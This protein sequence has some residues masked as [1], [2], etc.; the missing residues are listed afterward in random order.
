LRWVLGIVLAAVSLTAAASAAPVELNG[1][2]AILDSV[3]LTVLGPR[4]SLPATRQ[5]AQLVEERLTTFLHQSGYDLAV[6][7]AR[8]FDGVIEVDIDE[9][10]L[11]KVIVLGTDL[12]TCLRMRLDL[13][14]AGRVYNR[15]EL[16]RRLAE[17][18]EKYGVGDV[19]TEL[20]PIPAPDQD[21]PRLVA[22]T[23]LHPLGIA[24]APRRYELRVRIANASGWSP[25]VTPSIEVSSLE[26]GALGAELRAPGPAPRSRALL[27]ARVAAGSRGN[28]ESQGSRLALSSADVFAALFA[29]PVSGDLRPGIGA[30]LT[31]LDR[32]RQDLGLDGFHFATLQ[33]VAFIQDSVSPNLGLWMGGGIERR[34]LLSLQRAGLATSPAVEATPRA[35]TRPFGALRFAY[36]FDPETLRRD[37]GDF[38]QLGARF[39]PPGGGARDGAAYLHGR[40]QHVR[41]LGWDEFWVQGFGYLLAGDV[42]FTEEESLGADALHG[43]F[44]GTDYTRRLV[45]AGF[46]YR[47]SLWRD[48]FKLGMFT[49]VA[50]YQPVEPITDRGAG[51]RFAAAA[52][53]G[54]HMLVEDTIAFDAFLSV[55]IDALGR[56]GVGAQLG[57]HQAF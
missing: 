13:S 11:D 3:Y 26:G 21:R 4:D 30:G 48:V 37:R 42:F 40:F 8:P 41:M 15:P 44:A 20:V 39:A 49:N 46:E 28:L 27:Q 33:A 10:T 12:V 17:L 1:N 9:G 7:R 24:D 19:T 55:G 6:V 43:A 47:Y 51:A 57:L 32:Q 38:V 2:V 45:G 50:V 29:P 34:L 16:E 25:G 14:M 5:G 35:Q 53:P 22:M 23:E 52:G 36:R 18:R 56:S 31:L 54:I